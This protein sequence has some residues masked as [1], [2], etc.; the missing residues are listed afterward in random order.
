[1]H[2]GAMQCGALRTTASVHAIG[3]PASRDR[4]II[5]K[6]KPVST[7]ATDMADLSKQPPPLVRLQAIMAKDNA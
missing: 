4:R 2:W 6:Q 3:T 1:M 7:L 5:R